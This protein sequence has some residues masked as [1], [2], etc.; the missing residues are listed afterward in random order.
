V[1]NLLLI[2]AVG[3]G[4]ALVDDVDLAVG[5]GLAVTAAVELAVGLGL[6]VTAAVELAVGVGLTE[7]GDGELVAGDGLA[8]DFVALPPHA[9]TSGNSAMTSTSMYSEAPFGRRFMILLQSDVGV[10]R[11]SPVAYGNIGQIIWPFTHE[12][13]GV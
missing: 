11:R 9:A 1:L 13:C 4:L 7:R 6:A 12:K 5:V 10:R 2:V 3:L 8:L